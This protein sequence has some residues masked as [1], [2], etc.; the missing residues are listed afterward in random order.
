MWFTKIVVFRIEPF[1]QVGLLMKNEYSKQWKRKHFQNNFDS[2]T[3]HYG[4]MF[5]KYVNATNDSVIKPEIRQ[6]VKWINPRLCNA[7]TIVKP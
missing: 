7:Q 2:V 6:L 4:S 5:T 3:K 1:L